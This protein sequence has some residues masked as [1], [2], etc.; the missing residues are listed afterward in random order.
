MHPLMQYYD[1]TTNPRWWTAAMLKI[2]ISPYQRIINWFWWNLVHNNIFRTKRQTRDQKWQFSK[3]KMADGRCNE[4]SVWPCQLP[5]SVKFCKGKQNSMA[6]KVTWH[7]IHI[8]KIQ[9]G[10][11][12]PSWK[13]L[14]HYSS[15]GENL[16]NFD[17]LW[18]TTA[19]LEL[20]DS[21]VTKYEYN[22]LK[23]A[24]GGRKKQFSCITTFR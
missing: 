23:I 12:P 4:N 15:I 7:K 6:I 2:V 13:W 24:D 20:D 17:E 14:F 16:S 21:Q 8:S 1:V 3:F 11:W 5:I 10:G 22:K 19:D 18:C 9:H